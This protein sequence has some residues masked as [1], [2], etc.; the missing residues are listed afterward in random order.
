MVKMKSCKNCQ[1]EIP[2]NVPHCEYCGSSQRSGFLWPAVVVMLCAFLVI[3]WTGIHKTSAKPVL[4]SA[5]SRAV[6]MCEQAVRQKASHPASVDFSEFG[7]QPPTQMRGG[8]YQVRLAFKE[9][10]ALGD[11]IAKEAICT[12]KDGKLQSFKEPKP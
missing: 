12:V 1:E 10:D 7:S 5:A 9:T 4:Q 8:G 6:S 11:S 2:A 3:A